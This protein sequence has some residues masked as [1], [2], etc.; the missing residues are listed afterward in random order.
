M[1]SEWKVASLRLGNDE[2]AYQVYRLRN[3]DVVD[4]SGNREWVGELFETKAEAR[5]LADEMNRRD[6]PSE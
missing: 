5:A 6:D 4:H 3:I 2:M 1:K